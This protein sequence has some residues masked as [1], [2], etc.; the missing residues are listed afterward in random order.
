MARVTGYN[1]AGALQGS[2]TIGGGGGSPTGITL[3][4]SN[5]SQDLWIVDSTT[6]KV[7]QYADGRNAT[8]GTTQTATTTFALAA[9]N[10][11][12]QG[13]AD[14]PAPGSLLTT[15]A[16]VLAEPVSEE[17]ALVAHDA[18]LASMYYEPQ[19]KVRVDRTGRVASR[20]AVVGVSVADFTVGAAPSYLTGDNRWAT[21]HDSQ[22]DVD[23]LF[24]EWD[25]D[26]LELVS[27]PDL[28]R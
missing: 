28:G 22:A 25:A 15:D 16:S 11:N 10:T 3:D 23:D 17:A 24:A 27:L 20:N 14:P 9:G 7:F 8:S 2:W 26:P 18:A 19:R 1:M 21:D 4:P 5:V 13:I 6:D 12:P